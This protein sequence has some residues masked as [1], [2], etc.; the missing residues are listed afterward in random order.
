MVTI[1]FSLAR[2]YLSLTVPA[3]GN[4]TILLSLDGNNFTPTTVNQSGLVDYLPTEFG[5]HSLAVGNVP[6]GNLT[7]TGYTLLNIEGKR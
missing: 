6:G 7:V 3:T 1:L 5:D 4:G 2:R